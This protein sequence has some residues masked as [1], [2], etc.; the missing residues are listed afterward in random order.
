M[1]VWLGRFLKED[2]TLAILCL[3]WPTM[4]CG[5]KLIQLGNKDRK[6]MVKSYFDANFGNIG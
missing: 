4:D 6:L 1:G 2:A 5:N 3:K